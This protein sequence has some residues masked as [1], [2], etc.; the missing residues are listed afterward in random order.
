MAAPM[1]VFGAPLGAIVV[2]FRRSA[3]SNACGYYC[4]VD[5]YLI[6]VAQSQIAAA[7]GFKRVEIARREQSYER[8][9]SRRLQESSRH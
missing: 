3:L 4:G 8:A 5:G 9:N 1:L 7:I 2:A 6:S